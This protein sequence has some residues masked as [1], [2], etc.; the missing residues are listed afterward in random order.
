M[1]Y[2]VPR[3]YAICLCTPYITQVCGPC[4]VRE[5]SQK[6]FANR[7]ICSIQFICRAIAYVT[8]LC[9]RVSRNRFSERG[10]N[11]CQRMY[12]IILYKVLQGIKQL[13]RSMLTPLNR[14]E[15]NTLLHEFP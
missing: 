1:C 15:V 5:Q 12:V 3:L 2:K 13:L 9:N 4:Q 10:Q 11:M 6:C 8:K 14:V 7:Y